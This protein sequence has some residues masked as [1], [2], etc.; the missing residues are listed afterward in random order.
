M[1]AVSSHDRNNDPAEGDYI[2][3]AIYVRTT[4][5]HADIDKEWFGE[6]PSESE[7]SEIEAWKLHKRWLDIAQHRNC[8]IDRSELFLE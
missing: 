7:L 1:L 2:A 8:G 4:F 6:P 5:L 3:T